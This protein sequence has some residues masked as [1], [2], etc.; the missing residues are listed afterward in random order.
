MC[1]FICEMALLLPSTPTDFC[2]HMNLLER[3]NTVSSSWVNIMMGKAFTW[4]IPRKMYKC[5]NFDGVEWQR[6]S[7]LCMHFRNIIQHYVH[8]PSFFSWKSSPFVFCT[9]PSLILLVRFSCH[10]YSS[11]LWASYYY[12]WVN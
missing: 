12:T 3:W 11:D 5:V 8:F 2:V 7:V 4:W 10:D 1:R 9:I 6:H